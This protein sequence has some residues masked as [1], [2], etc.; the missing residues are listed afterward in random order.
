MMSNNQ[1]E[2]TTLNRFKTS[3]IN[4]IE[5]EL[6]TE[7]PEQAK[8]ISDIQFA[9]YFSQFVKP[10]IN[11]ERY[12]EG[13]LMLKSALVNIGYQ[14]PDLKREQKEKLIRYLKAFNEIID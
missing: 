11:Q 1:Q 10:Y 2:N 8:N 5:T 12:E 13:H 9:I 4:Y 14:L 7:I 3:L 6:N